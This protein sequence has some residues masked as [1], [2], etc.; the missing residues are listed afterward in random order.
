MTS[1][2]R[3]YILCPTSRE[4]VT[5][6]G[7]LFFSVKKGPLK[8]AKSRKKAYIH[9]FFSWPHCLHLHL[10]CVLTIPASRCGLAKVVAIQLHCV[11]R[12]FTPCI[13]RCFL[14][15]I[16]GQ[17]FHANP[18]CGKRFCACRVFDTQTIH[19]PSTICSQ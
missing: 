17:I 7:L 16:P 2:W 12:A 11:V 9:F 18:R 3:R 13:A 15:K 8:L 6:C 10:T 5:L 19:T 14:L 1:D 4:A